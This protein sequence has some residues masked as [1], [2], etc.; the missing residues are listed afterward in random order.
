M[1]T[2]TRKLAV[3]DETSQECREAVAALFRQA[4][5]ERE[6]AREET[7]TI[8]KVAFTG[9][10]KPDRGFTIT[11]SYLLAPNS[12]DALIEIFRD[13]EPCRLF[14]YPAYKIFNLQAHFSEIITGEID[15]SF[16]GYDVAGWT[17]FSVVRPEPAP[18]GGDDE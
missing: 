10:E 14:L 5:I 9:P 7:L 11:A 16:A 4:I 1:T 8:D 15:G 13:G 18:A 17:G 2:I 12:G 6:T 3:Q